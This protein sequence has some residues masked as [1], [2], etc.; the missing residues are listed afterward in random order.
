MI[1]KINLEEVIG[2]IEEPFHPVE[3]VKVND[4]VVRI[5]RVEENTTG[6]NIRM[7]MSSFTFLKV[8]ASFN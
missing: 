8:K 3:V 2:R 1:Q 4:Q 7:R 5:A 6:I